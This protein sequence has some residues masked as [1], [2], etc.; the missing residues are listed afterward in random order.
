MLSFSL[1]YTEAVRYIHIPLKFF[2]L[3]RA[4]NAGEKGKLV[5]A[6]STLLVIFRVPNSFHER[7]K[8]NERA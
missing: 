1:R 2:L 6:G 4:I 5:F 7:E 8:K 3:L